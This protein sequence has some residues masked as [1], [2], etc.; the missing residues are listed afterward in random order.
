MQGDSPTY[1]PS[2][3]NARAASTPDHDDVS[4]TSFT[5]A[6]VPGRGEG[7]ARTHPQPPYPFSFMLLY[8]A[9]MG[10]RHFSLTMGMH[11]YS[12]YKALRRSLGTWN[13]VLHH[14]TGYKATMWLVPWER[15]Q[16]GTHCKL[17]VL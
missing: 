14:S 5:A 11:E 3:S 7:L 2:N 13:K 17:R 12:Y 16:N 1:H 8:K 6:G 15:D 9:D 4:I 10:T